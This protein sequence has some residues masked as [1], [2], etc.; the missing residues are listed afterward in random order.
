LDG[1]ALKR[2]ILKQID[3]IDDYGPCTF[4]RKGGI[5]NSNPVRDFK[6]V[7]VSSQNA[8]AKGVKISAMPGGSTH[9]QEE[10][11]VKVIATLPIGCIQDQLAHSLDT[12]EMVF[13]RV[14]TSD[15]FA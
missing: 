6:L 12:N 9:S 4:T 13:L 7:D 5:L 14:S 2:Q 10:S 8:V 11:V 1:T 3:K 15:G